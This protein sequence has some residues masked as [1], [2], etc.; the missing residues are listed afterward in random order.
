MKVVRFFPARPGAVLARRLQLVVAHRRQLD[1]RRPRHRLWSVG[2]D[3]WP[4]H[5]AGARRSGGPNYWN[6]DLSITHSIPLGTR[7]IE[8]RIESFNLLNHF[9]WG[10]PAANQLNF[11]NGPFGRITTQAGAPRIIEL[12]VKYDFWLGGRR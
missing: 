6:I 4:S 1:H 11:D 12:G 8:A 9:N 5:Q 3:G 10:A 2:S 7:R